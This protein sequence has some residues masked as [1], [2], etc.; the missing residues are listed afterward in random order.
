MTAPHLPLPVEAMPHRGNALL[1]DAVLHADEERLTAELQVRPGTSFSDADG[2]LPGWAGAE[3]MAEAIA[4]YAGCRS[5]RRT[6]RRAQIGLLLGIRNY[7]SEVARFVPGA[8]LIVETVR[9]S[10][11]SAGSGVFDCRIVRDERVVATATLTVFQPPDE[12]FLAEE[13]AR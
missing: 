5:L 6:G 11:D 8:R 10:D 4:A 3:I 12:S 7:H 13:R 2:G 1:L 9:S